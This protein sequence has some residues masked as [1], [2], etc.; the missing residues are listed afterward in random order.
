MRSKSWTAHGPWFVQTTLVSTPN[1]PV[2]AA[3][4]VQFLQDVLIPYSE[5]SPIVGTKVSDPQILLDG[6]LVRIELV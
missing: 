4:T 6:T 5:P 3:A 2:H 1:S